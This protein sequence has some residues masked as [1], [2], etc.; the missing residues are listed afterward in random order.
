[1]FDVLDLSKTGLKSLLFFSSSFFSVPFQ[2]NTETP[3]CIVVTSVW[4]S[5]K[6]KDVYY[7]AGLEATPFATV[8]SNKIS[9]NLLT[10]PG[11]T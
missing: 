7:S 5:S 10:K 11:S 6:Q 3:E 8:T 2:H 4:K 1:M 9:H